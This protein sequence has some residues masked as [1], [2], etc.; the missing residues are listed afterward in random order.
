M[1]SGGPMP[2]RRLPLPYSGFSC[3]FRSPCDS[4]ASPHM[5]RL[6]I[7]HR[8]FLYGHTPDASPHTLRQIPIGRPFSHTPRQIPHSQAISPY[9]SQ[10][11]QSR[12]FFD[13]TSGSSPANPQPIPSS[14]HP[15]PASHLR[16]P[17]AGQVQQITQ[18]CDWGV[19]S[20]PARMVTHAHGQ[21]HT[22]MRISAR[23]WRKPFHRD[24]RVRFT[25]I[26]ASD[27]PTQIP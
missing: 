5:G 12:F 19:P 7:R 1:W 18:A 23:P 25:R 2:S 8:G 17:S 26:H 27:L 11:L 21:S 14:R 20:P 22:F 6:P 3:D 4:A 16:K 10:A 15:E 24:Q 9:D 13:E